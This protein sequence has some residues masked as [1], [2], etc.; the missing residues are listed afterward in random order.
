MLYNGSGFFSEEGAVI[1]EITNTS[2]ETKKDTGLYSDYSIEKAKRGNT[3]FEEHR[4]V[5]LDNGLSPIEAVANAIAS[6]MAEKTAKG[7]NKI[8]SKSV[9]GMLTRSAKVWGGACETV[10]RKKRETGIVRRYLERCDSLAKKAGFILSLLKGPIKAFSVALIVFICGAFI[11]R[12]V[13][14]C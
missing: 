4:N 14:G 11:K 12:T 5:A 9:F 1:A 10:D 13:R 6:K 7:K 3:S 2:S 8:F